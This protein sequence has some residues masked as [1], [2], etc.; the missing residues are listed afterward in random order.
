MNLVALL[1]APAVV[2]MSFGENQN[3]ALRIAIAVVAALIIAGAVY[4]SK[5]RTVAIAESEPEAEP[6]DSVRV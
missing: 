3:D 1:I 5:R 4:V 2:S 6:S